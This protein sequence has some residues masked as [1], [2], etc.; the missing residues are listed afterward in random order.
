MRLYTFLCISHFWL[1]VVHLLGDSSEV[2]E[3]KVHC[4]MPKDYAI[5]LCTIMDM[6]E[7]GRR[8]EGIEHSTHL[9][10]DKSVLY[11]GLESIDG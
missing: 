11:F 3:G 2:C 6:M 4:P 5:L 8:G 7:K 10:A 1:F 9:Q